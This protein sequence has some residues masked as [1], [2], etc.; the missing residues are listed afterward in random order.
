M[1]P[2]GTSARLDAR[3]LTES[4]ALLTGSTA[5]DERPQADL[6]GARVALLGLLTPE[7][8]AALRDGGLKAVDRVTAFPAAAAVIEGW[9]LASWWGTTTTTRGRRRRGKP[10]SR[11]RRRG[12]KPQ[13]RRPSWE[14]KNS[15]PTL[16]R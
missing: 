2:V 4:L 13:K 14:T 5:D 15:G 11:W 12:G 1:T 3:C 9:L 8:A 16:I 6:D 7:R 10:S